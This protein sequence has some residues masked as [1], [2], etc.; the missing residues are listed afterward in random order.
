MVNSKT[1][2]HTDPAAAK[3]TQTISIH[4]R[5]SLLVQ[6]VCGNVLFGVFLLNVVPCIMANHLVLWFV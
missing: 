1:A 4:P 2:K 3:Q 6:D 5:A